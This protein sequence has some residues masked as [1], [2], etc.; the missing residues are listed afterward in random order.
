MCAS[1]QARK[2]PPLRHGYCHES[3]IGT[4]RRVLAR[5]KSKGQSSL[6]RKTTAGQAG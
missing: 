1:T 4:S 6:L 2:M 3:M 5:P